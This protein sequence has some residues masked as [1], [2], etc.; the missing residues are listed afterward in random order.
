MNSRERVLAALAG[1]EPDRVPYCE[2]GVDRALAQKLMGWGG[3][4]WWVGEWQPTRHATHLAEVKREIAKLAFGVGT[5]HKLIHKN[6]EFVPTW[7]AWVNMA[8]DSSDYAPP[9]HYANS[10]GGALCRA[11]LAALGVE[12]EQSEPANG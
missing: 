11:V 4:D 1:D 3:A 6:G 9:L 12:I 7:A 5:E 2:L 8:Y 10:E